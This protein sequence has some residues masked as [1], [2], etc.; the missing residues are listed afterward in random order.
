MAIL[1]VGS[2]AYDTVETPA[3]RRERQLGGSASYFALAA[4]PF[5]PVG[6]VGAVGHE[7]RAVDLEILA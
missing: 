2:V 5:A 4:A 1:A 7:F 3:E 6:V